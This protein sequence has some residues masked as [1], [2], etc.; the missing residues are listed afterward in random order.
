MKILV[1]FCIMYGLRVS[2]LFY[3]LK[4]GSLGFWL[5][6]GRGVRAVKLKVEVVLL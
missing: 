1:Y 6:G 2:L 5:R 3:E 4:N